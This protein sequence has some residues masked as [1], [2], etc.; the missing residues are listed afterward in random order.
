[1]TYVAYETAL[2]DQ[3]R[4]SLP[5]AAPHLPFDS[6]AFNAAR[7]RTIHTSR[8]AGNIHLDQLPWYVETMRGREIFCVHDPK[9]RGVIRTVSNNGSLYVDWADAYSA[10]KELASPAPDGNK[11]VFRS[12]LGPSDFMDYALLQPAER[13]Q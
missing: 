3:P 10:E 6:A 1:M 9:I 13:P 4:V 5:P 8:Q 2:A 7:T 12:S 11:T